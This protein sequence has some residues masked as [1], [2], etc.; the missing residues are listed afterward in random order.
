M[1]S[2]EKRLLLKLYQYIPELDVVLVHQKPNH[3]RDAFLLVQT[4]DDQ[5]SAATAQRRLNERDTLVAVGQHSAQVHVL[6]EIQI[7]RLEA[8]I[9]I[10]VVGSCQQRTGAN[11]VR[12]QIDGGGCGVGVA[13]GVC[14]DGVG[15]LQ[16]STAA[17]PRPLWLLPLLL[18]L[19]S[20]HVSVNANDV[21]ES[22]RPNLVR[23]PQVLE[24]RQA[25]A[26]EYLL[27]GHSTRQCAVFEWPAGRQ[28]P[29]RCGPR[30]GAWSQTPGK[31]CNTR[32]SFWRPPNLTSD[33]ASMDY[34]PNSI[35]RTPQNTRRVCIYTKIQRANSVRAARASVALSGPPPS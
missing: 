14:C 7:E 31:L 23:R 18:C 19:M 15:S 27:Q 9:Q 11:L 21:R 34:L 30:S 12:I 16:L 4:I 22:V 29:V 6:T 25:N 28:K 1:F 13:A 3:H 2:D 5:D 35:W 20:H 10:V 24:Q 8:G 26:R 17:G 33:I 32:N